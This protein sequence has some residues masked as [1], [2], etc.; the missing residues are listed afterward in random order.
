MRKK[1]F[2]KTAAVLLALC[3][4]SGSI[5]TGAAA[6]IEPVIN[7]EENL[8]Q[9]VRL[10]DKIAADQKKNNI[11]L[12][13][14][15]LNF[16][17]GILAEGAAGDT[18][19]KLNEYLGT[20]KYTEYAMVYLEKLNAYNKNGSKLKIAD[21]VWGDDNIA[22]E[23]KF[24]ESVSENFDSEVK[25]LNFSDGEAASR[26]INE[27]CNK[28]TEGLIPEIVTSEAI[29]GSTGLCVTN[30][31]Y[32]EAGWEKAWNVSEKAETFG[33][34]GEE[35]IYMTGSAD[36]YYE[37]EYATAFGKNYANGLS[38]I[39][40]LPKKEGE[41]TL[42]GLDINGLMNS[43]PEYDQVSCKMPKLNFETSAELTEYLK[44]LGLENI[45]S[46]NADFSG[47]TKSGINVSSILQKTKLELDEKK[48]K[49]A[50]VTAIFSDK[51]AAPVDNMII[52][53]VNLQRP[54]AFL[55]YDM[56]NDEILFMGKVITL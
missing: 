55:V 40:I 46:E 26:S 32:F 45:F 25:N 33:N 56:S 20:D 42:E 29:S 51:C 21:A 6:R 31:L 38:F 15:S 16:A 36:D 49:A 28:N 52:K 19:E 18:K 2:A 7:K 44:A 3:S 14:T 9:S 22:L 4:V 47:I 34:N 50:A 41:F 11:M 17:L 30:S 48:T 53:E 5:N 37:N 54:F 12:S 39:G 8:I 27:W 35:T 43:N 23:Q 24:K 10:T 1:L 13:P